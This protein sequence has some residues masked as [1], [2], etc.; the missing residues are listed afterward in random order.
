[1]AANIPQ[2]SAMVLAADYS[3]SGRSELPD[4]LGYD[5]LDV[6]RR[7]Y[8][9]VPRALHS[10][11]GSFV[12]WGRAG[13][14]V[15]VHGVR[16]RP[17]D[18]ASLSAPIQLDVPLGRGRL[19]V[20]MAMEGGDRE[21]EVVGGVE[22]HYRDGSVGRTVIRYGQHVRA[23]FDS[24]PVLY[25]ERDGRDFA[26]PISVAKPLRSLL[27]LPGKRFDLRVLGATFVRGQGSHNNH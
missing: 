27:F 24:R 6:F 19:W 11:P 14:E 9:R 16:F 25:S 12:L 13:G 8:F 23:Y 15:A 4:R 2:F 22:L 26:T 20:L 10:L 21:N 7:M 5:P 17:Q 1:M 3:W 18:F